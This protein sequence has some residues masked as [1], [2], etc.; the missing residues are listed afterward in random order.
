MVWRYRSVVNPRNMADGMAD[1]HVTP[2][3]DGATVYLTLEV[4]YAL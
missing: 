4:K 3:H 1:R 2:F